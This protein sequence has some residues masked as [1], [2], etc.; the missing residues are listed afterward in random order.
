MRGVRLELSNH[1][2]MA[3]HHAISMPPSF[4]MGEPAYKR[5]IAALHR[6]C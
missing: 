4:K 3:N 1:A 2:L 6:A 5:D